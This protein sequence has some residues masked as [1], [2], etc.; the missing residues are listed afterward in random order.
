MLRVQMLSVDRTGVGTPIYEA[1][2][3]PEWLMNDLARAELGDMFAV[4]H[5]DPVRRRDG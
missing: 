4:Y 2:P 1:A 5:G 3:T